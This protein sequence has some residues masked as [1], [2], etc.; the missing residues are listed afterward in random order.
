MTNRG[1]KQGK[2]PMHPSQMVDRIKSLE[3]QLE[4]ALDLIKQAQTVI[5][6]Q[7]WQRDVLLDAI[8]EHFE[9]L[10]QP[11]MIDHRLYVARD[12]VVQHMDQHRKQDQQDKRKKRR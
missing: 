6:C 12:C 5:D 2:Q 11:T 10:Q 4:R 7:R 8:W 1:G 3:A 9:N